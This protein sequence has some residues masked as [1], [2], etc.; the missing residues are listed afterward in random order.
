MN[1]GPLLIINHH[2]FLKFDDNS[3]KEM[4]CIKHIAISK[5]NQ[6]SIRTQASQFPLYKFNEHTK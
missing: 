6:L 5:K 4:E 2:Y 1:P 3:S